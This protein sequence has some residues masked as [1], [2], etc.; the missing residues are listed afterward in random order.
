MDMVRSTLDLIAQRPPENAVAIARPHQVAA[1]AKFF[2]RN[3]RGSVFYAMKAN[4]APWVLDALWA[5]GV[6]DFDVASELEVRLMAERFPDARLAFTHPVKSR[7]AIRRAYA[8]H[9][10]RI[11]ALDTQDELDKILEETDG[12]RDLQLMVRV[13]VPADHALHKLD[14]KF[15]AE[16]AEAVRLLRAARAHAAKLCV[17]FHVGSQCMRAEPYQ[18]A[19]AMIGDLI[20]EAGVTVD[21]IDVGG[22]FPTMYA[23][24][25]PPPLTDYFTTIDA[26]FEAMPVPRNAEL[27]C[28]PGRALAAEGGSHLVRIELRKGDRLYIN[29]GSY[30]ALFDAAHCGVQFPVRLVRHAE[31][32]A[33]SELGAFALYGPTCDSIDYMQGPFHLPINVREGDYVEIGMTGAY[34][35]ALATAFNG[36]GATETVFAADAPMHTMYGE[37][38]A[39]SARRRAASRAS[40][41]PSVHPKTSRGVGGK[42]VTLQR[43]RPHSFL[44]PIG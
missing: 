27:W 42:V 14:K 13:A 23:D 7:G 4:P 25:Q 16:G 11:F 44:A 29:D 38:Q 3:F 22:G 6:R 41:K 32:A 10:V 39:P 2:L 19:M 1:A 30:G 24:G 21:V 26:A 34:G 40:R 20:R 17:S 18:Q 43:A 35:A 5:A 8:E 31:G 9:R 15:G 12:A 36:F 33:P 28:E 37:P